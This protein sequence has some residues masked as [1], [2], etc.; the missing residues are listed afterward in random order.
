MWKIWPF[1][2]IFVSHIYH[3]FAFV[4][5]KKY[6]FLLPTL[7]IRQKLNQNG[8]DFCKMENALAPKICTIMC[9]NFTIMLVGCFLKNVIFE[10]LRDFDFLITKLTIFAISFTPISCFC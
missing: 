7:K 8:A 5:Q 3:N 6:H 1:K 2:K 10:V 9:W 4:I